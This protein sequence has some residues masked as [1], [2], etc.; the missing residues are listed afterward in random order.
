MT[1][2][3]ELLQALSAIIRP[4]EIDDWLQMPNSAFEARKPIELMNEGNLQPIWNMIAQIRYGIF[5]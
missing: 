2:K 4:N 1:E 3:E 5:S